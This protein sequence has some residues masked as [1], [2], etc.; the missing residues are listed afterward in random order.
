M[1]DT[2][3]SYMYILVWPLYVQDRGGGWGGGVERDQI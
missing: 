2:L 1:F 3:Y